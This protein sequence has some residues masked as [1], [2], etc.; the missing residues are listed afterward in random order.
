MNMVIF[1]S[2]FDITRGYHDT[3]NQ[4]HH[5]FDP[6]TVLSPMAWTPWKSHRFFARDKFDGG[7]PYTYSMYSNYICLV[8]SS[9]FLNESWLPARPLPKKAWIW[10]Y[11]ICL[12][13]YDHACFDLMSTIHGYVWMYTL[14]IKFENLFNYVTMF[15]SFCIPHLHATHRP[16]SI[17]GNR[18]LFC[19]HI[20]REMYQTNYKQPVEWTKRKEPETLKAPKLCRL[21]GKVTRL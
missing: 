3:F 11:T 8:L 16:S 14:Y 15:N 12:Y 20:Y 13:V 19:F 5:R 6:K 21:D 17:T 10:T 2:Y 18:S 7:Y 1:H 4:N 9:W